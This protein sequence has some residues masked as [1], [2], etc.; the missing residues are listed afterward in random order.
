MQIHNV[1]LKSSVLIVDD[2]PKNLQVLGSCLKEVGLHVEFAIDGHSA[3]AWLKKARFD[4]ILLDIMMPG[5]DGFEVCRKIKADTSTY[6]IPVI[7]ITAVTEL[8]SIV[9]GFNAGASDYITKPFILDELL[10]RVKTQ[11]ESVRSKQLI[12]EYLRKIEEKNKDIKSSIDY[13][14]YIQ[15]AILNSSENDSKHV[16]DYF[17]I[18]SPKDILS[19]DFYWTNCVK[20]QV[21][22]AVMD[23]TG[24]GVPGALMSIL[25]VTFLNEIIIHAGI[26]QP[27]KILEELR[28]KLIG[29][30]GQTNNL[31]SVKD[32]MEGAVLVF[33]T[34]TSEIQ[35]SGTQNPV[36]HISGSQINVT[37]SDKTPIGFFDNP[38]Q[39]SLNSI[40][41]KSGD[42]VY[43]FTDGY[44]DQFG[45]PDSKKIMKKRFKELLLRFHTLPLEMQKNKLEEFLNDWKGDLEQ[46]D[47]I[48]VFGIKF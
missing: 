20:D 47:D 11:L 36:V 33:N 21:I 14:R 38:T 34:S 10:V 9:K 23:C 41:I 37:K 40:K 42:M 2:S 5:I 1:S 28:I 45:G 17:I 43:M 18:D 30:L 12:I 39:F 15:Y 6:D 16:P 29:A 31:V 48:L 4:L 27:E 44:V 24:H 26:I 13:A 46:T 22:F 8:D 7:F 32:G 35:F 3:L 25:G 19:G